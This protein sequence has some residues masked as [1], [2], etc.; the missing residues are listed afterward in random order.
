MEHVE[1]EKTVRRSKISLVE[2]S[3]EQ[4]AL[5]KNGEG[6]WPGNV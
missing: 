6:T 1:E 3:T 2:G 5:M 4:E